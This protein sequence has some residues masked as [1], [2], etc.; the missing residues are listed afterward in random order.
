MPIELRWKLFLVHPN[1]L[2]NQVTQRNLHLEFFTQMVPH[3]K[4]LPYHISPILA[5]NWSMRLT[6]LIL[7][8]AALHLPLSQTVPFDSLHQ[9]ATPIRSSNSQWKPSYCNLYMYDISQSHWAKLS[10]CIG[11]IIMMESIITFGLIIT[12]AL[13]V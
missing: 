13:I 5:V 2:M 6:D 11:L 1:T 12:M 7:H 10:H 4:Y 9:K 3:T 8:D